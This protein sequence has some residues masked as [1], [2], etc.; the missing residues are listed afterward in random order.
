VQHYTNALSHL[1]GDGALHANRAAALIKL[2]SWRDAEQ[3]CDAALRAQAGHAK[4]L[5]R[6]CLVRLELG[7]P[8]QALQVRM[9]GWGGGGVDASLEG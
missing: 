1:P 5:V 3:D 6:R 8:L 9:G 2:R 7:K 4:A